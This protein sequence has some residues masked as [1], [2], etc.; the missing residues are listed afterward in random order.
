MPRTMKILV[1]DE[2]PTIR[3]IVKNLLGQLGFT[4]IDEAE[5]G[6]TALSKLSQGG[7]EFVI[8]DWDTPHMMGRELLAR[9]RAD[10]NLCRIPFL[11]LTAESQRAPVA[12]LEDGPSQTLVRPFNAAALGEKLAVILAQEPTC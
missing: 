1:V 9:I 11:M 7:Y 10:E 5:D 4:N 3:K 6:R 8:S 2:F 12:P